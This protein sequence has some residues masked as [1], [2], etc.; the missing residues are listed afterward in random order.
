[1][2]RILIKKR[3]SLQN[4]WMTIRV[5]YILIENSDT[6]QKNYNFCLTKDLSELM[7]QEY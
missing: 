3:K 5:G 2:R 7:K 4:R 6:K 1:M